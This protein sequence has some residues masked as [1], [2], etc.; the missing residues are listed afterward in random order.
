MKPRYYKVRRDVELPEYLTHFAGMIGEVMSQPFADTFSLYFGAS[1]TLEV[2]QSYLQRVE[3]DGLMTPT[4]D[5]PLVPVQHTGREMI[6]DD[7]AAIHKLLD[8]AGLPPAEGAVCDDQNCHSHLYHRIKWL[9]EDAERMRSA[10]ECVVDYA[11]HPES[12]RVNATEMDDEDKLIGA[13]M[14]AG[15]GLSKYPPI[16]PDASD[17]HRHVNQ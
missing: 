13:G 9:I 7:R 11:F 6:Y 3:M 2:P 17:S 8:E 1:G 15:F 14:Q 16:N 5:K 4:P 10:L 12:K